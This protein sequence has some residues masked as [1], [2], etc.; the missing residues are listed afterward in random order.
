MFWKE[1]QHLVT[2]ST[3]RNLAI[4]RSNA[5]YPDADTTHFGYQQ[6]AKDAKKPMVES[7]FHRVADRYDLMN[8]LMSCG[9]HRLWK[10]AFIKILHPVPPLRILD[11]AGGTGDIAFRIA[12]RFTTH[13]ASEKD[14][15]FTN[16]DS[17]VSSIIVSDI[18]SSM[19]QVGKE[20]A[21]RLFP[22]QAHLFDW[23]EADAEQ[24]EPFRENE[25]DAYT[26]AFGIRNVTDINKAL[27][28]AYRVL[29]PGG[30]FLCMEF[31]YVDNVLLRSLYDMYS[32]NV[33]PSLGQIIAK[34]RD[35][36]QYLVESIRQFPRQDE[37]KAM[38]HMVGFESIRHVNYSNGIVANFSG[39]KP[40]E[41]Q[42][43][44]TY[45]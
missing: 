37:F 38:M 14:A 3:R 30:R 29:R 36:Y 39:F 21:S 17:G 45:A 33:I 9:V 11:M 22:D 20:R 41:R 44:S 28:Q 43:T 7:V 23:I 42:E 16:E 4:G 13:S 5:A 34:D 32:T 25:F 15:F 12:E 1:I 31:S 19:L 35:S 2:K 27:Q 26:I 10:D 8:D 40:L 18:N 24:L 6:V